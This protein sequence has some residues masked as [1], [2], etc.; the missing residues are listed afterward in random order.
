M[1]LGNKIYKLRK[2]KGMSQEALA[3][4]VGTTRQAISKWEN[5]QGYPET[6]KLLL[7]SNV[8]EVSTDFLLKDEKTEPKSDEKGYYVSKE[9]ATGYIANEIKCG[10]YM[11]FGFAFFALAGIPY[12]LFS[13]TSIWRIL[14]MAVCIVAGI[15]AIVA[16]MFLS[17]DEYNVLKKEPLLFDYEYLKGLTNEYRS[18][19]RK[20]TAIAIPCTILFILGLLV[21]AV[22]VRG[23]I[24][25]SEYHSLIFLGLAI[26]VFGFV[27]SAAILEAYEM[28]V[29]NE[30]YSGSFWFKAKRNVKKKIDRW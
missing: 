8:F 11:S 24:P 13:T 12:T 23:M 15:T 25:W 22:T 17:K 29:H 27:Y 14:G 20:Y 10:K 30:A 1:S 5:D 28:L 2:E 21:L 3:E 19:K 7:L 26:G 9:V 18:V 4:Q 16:A 6:E